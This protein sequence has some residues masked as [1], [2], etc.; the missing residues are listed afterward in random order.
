MQDFKLDPSVYQELEQRLE[1]DGPAVAVDRLCEAL[2]EKKDY[3]NL[4]YAL[5]MK[6]RWEL[7][8]SPIPTSASSHLPEEFHDS[9]E[10]AIRQT[11]RTVGQL[12]L[13]EN[14]LPNAWMYYRMIG[15]PEKVAA[16]LEA[17]SPNPDD[18]EEGEK[19]DQVVMIAYQEG[20]NPRKGFDLIL[21]NY[22]LC[23]AITT[24]GG[25]NFP[26]GDEVRNHC[27]RQVTRALY[28]ELQERLLNEV[29][30]T[31]EK[32]P[33]ENMPVKEIVQGRF[34]LFGEDVYHVDVSHL[35]SV[36]QLSIHLEK[37]EE[38]EL[39]RELCEYGKRLSAGLQFD[40]EPP[41]ENLYE[42]HGIYLAVLAGENVEEGLAHFRQKLEENEPDEFGSFVAEVLVNLLLRI[43]RNEEA[44]EIASK[45]LVNVDERQLTCPG[46]VELCE[47]TGNYKRLAELAREHENAVHF[48]AGLIAQKHKPAKV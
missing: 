41:F 25:H 12:F 18:E 34:Y 6:R 14:D 21:E 30:A 16:A 38:L 29:A 45:Y 26:H 32:T 20:V 28:S 9:Y 2:R 4:F 10:E 22:G 24:L 11:A 47:R 37:G 39:A 5:L 8:V 19:L 48:L 33:P 43:G 42:D 3:N 35:A 23:N 7:G 13:D 40:S 1:S 31:E 44:L 17:Y 36:V 27:I 15:E 46:V